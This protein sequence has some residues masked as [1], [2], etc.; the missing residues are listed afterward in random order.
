MFREIQ[1]NVRAQYL[2][3]CAQEFRGLPGDGMPFDDGE[4]VPVLSHEDGVDDPHAA[5][6]FDDIPG[7][8]AALPRAIARDRG[9][10]KITEQLIA[11]NANG[12]AVIGAPV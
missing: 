12:M 6:Q 4:R 2:A 7:R 8:L 11:V 5:G 1:T 9:A 10:P 3:Q